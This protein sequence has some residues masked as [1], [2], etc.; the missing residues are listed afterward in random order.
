[1]TTTPYTPDPRNPRVGEVWER[2]DLPSDFARQRVVVSVTDHRVMYAT[3]LG[4]EP[5]MAWRANFEVWAA[6]ARCIKLAED[7]RG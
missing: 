2:A 6:K 1:M 3:T 4:G 5:Y 7:S